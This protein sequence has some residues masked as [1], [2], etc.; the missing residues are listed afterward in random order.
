MYM[1]WK[2]E[3][4]SWPMSR[5]AFKLL[6]DTQS[7]T[8]CLTLTL[9]SNRAVAIDTFNFLI[10]GSGASLYFSEDNTHVL[11]SGKSSFG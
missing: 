4:R 11:S 8:G 1:V 2:V 5:T 3:A 6:N 9:W 7:R 10:P